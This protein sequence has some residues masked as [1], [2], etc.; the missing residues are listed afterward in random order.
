MCISQLGAEKDAYGIGGLDCND[1]W[2]HWRWAAILISQHNCR[3][4]EL[5]FKRVA[6]L[7][8]Y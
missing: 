2:K 4:P 1:V 8:V 3:D 7:F 6:F 5:L